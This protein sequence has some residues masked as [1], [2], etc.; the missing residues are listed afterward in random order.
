MT[1]IS[2]S[3]TTKNVRCQCNATCHDVIITRHKT[4]K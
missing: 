1:V 3:G 2:Y 4:H